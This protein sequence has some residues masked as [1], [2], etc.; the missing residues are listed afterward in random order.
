VNVL[1][2]DDS[3]M[4][5]RFMTRVLASRSH[6][7]YTLPSPIGAT[8]TVIRHEIDVVVIDVN[9]PSVRGDRLASLFRTNDRMDRVGVVLVSGM[10]RDELGRLATE[11]GADAVVPK[12]DIET[13]LHDAIV[14]AKT[15]RAS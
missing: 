15:K 9:L 10:G 8:R 5:L 12:D 7:V 14:E 1:I 3:E 6:K 2:I 11:A 13:R 4:A